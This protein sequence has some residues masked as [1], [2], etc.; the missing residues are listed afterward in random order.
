[1]NNN[2]LVTFVHNYNDQNIRL[3]SDE[4]P[5][6]W[7]IKNKVSNYY[8]YP[9]PRIPSDFE[10]IENLI[11]GEMP[12]PTTP[13]FKRLPRFGFTGIQEYGDYVYAGSWNSVYKI[14]KKDLKLDNIISNHLMN[15]MHGIYVDKDIVGTI[16]TGKDTIV[17]SNHEGEI[18][19]YFT[20]KN[21]L[22]V[23]K[24][25]KI[26]KYDWRFISKQFRGSTGCWHFN[27]IQKFGNELWLTAR[28]TNSFVV[29]NLKTLKAH[30]RLMNFFTPALIHDGKL[31]NGK[32]YFTS[33]DGKIIIAEEASKASFQAREEIKKIHLFDRDLLTKTI[34]L[35]ETEL[36]REPNWCRG[37]DI[38]DDLLF[39]TIDGRYGTD[40]SF[41]LL[42]LN[43]D[44]KVFENHRLRWSDIG[45]ESKI[46]FVTGFDVLVL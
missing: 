24:D 31:K 36:G 4:V 41:G 33:I 11:K 1:L 8:N 26:E 32:Y 13:N 40:L 23:V 15:D 44:G 37:I 29:V 17:F 27:F 35:N 16:L 9:F 19:D 7:Q 20:I 45:D 30:L 43:E 42:V 22:K 6:L 28:N 14:R 38:K 39:V 10:E 46:R 25:E 12:L 2:I 5:A 21:D 34:R 3:K 18:I